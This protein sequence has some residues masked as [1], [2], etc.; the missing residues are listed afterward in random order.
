[1]EDLWI[2]LPARLLCFLAGIALFSLPFAA[3]SPT[4]AVAP[5][6]DSSGETGQ[7]RAGEIE[8][9]AAAE[10][11]AI[12]Q[13]AKATALIFNAQATAAA[14]VSRLPA[15]QSPAP[16]ETSSTLKIPVQNPVIKTPIPAISPA[17]TLD[18]SQVQIL[19]VSLGEQAGL[20]QV[21]FKAPPVLARKWQQGDMYVIAEASGAAYKEVPNLPLIGMLIAHPNQPGQIGFVMLV[22]APHPLH[23]GDAVTIILGNFKQEHVIIK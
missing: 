19:G 13:R 22:N 18:A 7:S 8:A 6:A 5:Q 11:T 15:Q 23:P 4:A 14:L 17:S 12:I 1:M 10:A 16:G 21:R 20:I 3:C 2:K 9:R